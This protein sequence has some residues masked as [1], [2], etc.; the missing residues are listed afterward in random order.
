[1]TISEDDFLHGFEWSISSAGVIPIDSNSQNCFKFASDRF[2]SIYKCFLHVCTGAWDV[3]GS[4]E[5]SIDPCLYS[6]RFSISSL[7]NASHHCSVEVS[8]NQ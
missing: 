3:D 6:N 4:R 1:M 5:Y 2:V 7:H 8:P